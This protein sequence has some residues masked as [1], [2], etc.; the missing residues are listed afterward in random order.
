M[1]NNIVESSNESTPVYVETAEAAFGSG[2]NLRCQGM[3]RIL[4]L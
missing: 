1:V 3:V 2:K 4:L